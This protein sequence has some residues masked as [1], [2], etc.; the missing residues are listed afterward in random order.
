[1]RQVQLF[2]L[3][4]VVLGL[5][6]PPGTADV[7]CPPP[8]VI[9]PAPM[10]VAAKMPV[11]NPSNKE[12]RTIGV[13]AASPADVPLA[14]AYQLRQFY[15]DWTFDEARNRY[16]AYWFFQPD[17]N[18]N[19]Y[20]RQLV[21]WYP[22]DAERRLYLFF[23]NVEKDK[24]WGCCTNVLHPEHSE[25]VQKWRFA[26]KGRFSDRLVPGDPPIPGAVDTLAVLPP[27]LPPLRRGQ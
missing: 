9:V 21:F 17:P 24:F 3:G 16:F 4:V 25:R 8:K 15:T 19:S 20:Q 6:S 27:P 1:M 14:E 2:A 23:Y 11:L 22:D 13:V 12:V 10:S 18:V 5:C 7:K 26:E